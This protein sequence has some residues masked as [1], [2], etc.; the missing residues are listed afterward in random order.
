M[1][2]PTMITSTPPLFI[3][4]FASS[5]HW[6]VKWVCWHVHKFWSNYFVLN[7]D[8]M[9]LLVF[10][11]LGPCTIITLLKGEEPCSTS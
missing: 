7:T 5:Q 9:K 8:A 11:W 4:E 1:I 6:G 10:P 3:L 2:W